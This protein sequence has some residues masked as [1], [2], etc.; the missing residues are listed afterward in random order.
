M[1][2]AGAATSIAV[3]QDREKPAKG[4]LVLTFSDACTIRSVDQVEA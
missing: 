3:T 1:A 2:A 4:H